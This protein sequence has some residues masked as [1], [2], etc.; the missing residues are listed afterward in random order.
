MNIMLTS[1]GRRSYMVNYFKKAVNGKVYV[2]NC[3]ENAVS[4]LY[5]D[6]S[7]VTPFIYEDG[8]IDFL[9]KY[10]ERKNITVIV[11]L[12]DVDLYILAMNKELFKKRGIHVIVSD[13][14]V[15]E[16]CND[17]WKM[18]CFLERNGVLTPRTYLY[19]D[20]A[21]KA[22][23]RR[24]L[25]FPL[26]IKPRWGMG[27]IGVYEANDIEELKILYY[28]AKREIKETYL[29]YESKQDYAK[30]ILIQEKIIGKEY[31]ADII[32]DL[33]G[34]YQNTIVKEKYSMRAGETDIAI[35]KRNDIIEKLGKK[36]SKKLRHIANLD[37]DFIVTNERELHVIDLNARFGGGYPFSHCAGVDLP[38]AIIMWLQG[39][40][41]QEELL[42]PQFNVKGYKEINVCK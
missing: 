32:N 9:L 41:V 3:N 13:V 26:I 31:G 22:I 30:S 21:V 28:K 15:I 17:K 38:R 16:T 10:C 40:Q 23:G 7:V 33:K 29:R 11:P 39:N 19:I 5:A 25:K 34:R 42:I 12:F 18:K 37:A 4:F 2:G 35:I 27:S 36:I 24:E 8:Y 20:E 1:A 6:E 14:S